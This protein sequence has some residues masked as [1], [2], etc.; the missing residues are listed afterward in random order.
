MLKAIED[1]GKK[2]SALSRAALAA[3]FTDEALDAKNG[4]MW[5]KA[6][7]LLEAALTLQPRREN[8]R[9][10]LGEVKSTAPPEEQFSPAE[11]DSE[12]LG[13]IR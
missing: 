10:R 13:E 4:R 5:Q 3:E 11:P 9:K 8:A 12:T 6:Y 7:T 1:D 2:L